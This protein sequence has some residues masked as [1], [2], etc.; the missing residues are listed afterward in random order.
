M[1]HINT[2]AMSNI[3]PDNSGIPHVVWISIGLLNGVKRSPHSPRIWLTSKSGSNFNVTVTI[4]DEPKLIH[5][6]LDTVT[7]DKVKQF[8]TLNR[9]VLIAHWNDETDSYKALT[10]IKSINSQHMSGT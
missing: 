2:W 9:D 1:K 6:N 8:I 10:Q 7:F 3:Y 4:E 5:G